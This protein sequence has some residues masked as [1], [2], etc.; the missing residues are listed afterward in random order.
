MS[1]V[2]VQTFDI[3]TSQ[4]SRYHDLEILRST[5]RV[6][7]APIQHIILKDE[8]IPLSEQNASFFRVI[9]Q[10]VVGRFHSIRESFGD[11]LN[12]FVSGLGVAYA[13]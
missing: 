6:V 1:N 12:I 5:V 3:W 10:T 11:G 9:S 7:I 2:S 13:F 4:R 8:R